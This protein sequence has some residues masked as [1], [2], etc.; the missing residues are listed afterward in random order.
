MRTEGRCRADLLEGLTRF[1]ALRVW[2]SEANFL[3]CRVLRGDAR[4]VAAGVR[5]RGV[6]IRVLDGSSPALAGCLRISVGTSAENAALL[7][8]L[9]AVL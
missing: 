9:K 3:L 8:A 7:A 1:D 5:E 2:P 4:E 6:L